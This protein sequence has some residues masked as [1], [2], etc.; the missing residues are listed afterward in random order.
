MI[1]KLCKQMT[2]ILQHAKKKSCKILRPDS[3]FNPAIQLCYDIIHAYLQLI[4]LKEG[5]AQNIG[6]IM[7]FSKHIEKLE[8]LTLDK[9]KDRLQL[10][11]IRKLELRKQAKGLH[12][13]HL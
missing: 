7:K 13:V 3:N 6:N 8:E 4:R 10:A 12:K 2:E 11:R 5:K 1:K 9:L